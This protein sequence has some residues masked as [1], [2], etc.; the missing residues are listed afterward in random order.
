M[1]ALRVFA[2]LLAGCALGPDYERPATPTAGAYPE[3]GK[4]GDAVRAEWWRS[5]DDP[6]LDAL[7]AKAFAAN[8]DLRV[9]VARIAE[10]GAVLGEVEGAALPQVDA[11]VTSQQI[12][13][14]EGGFNPNLA[15]NGRVRTNHGA[16]I[17]LIPAAPSATQP[18]PLRIAAGTRSD[19]CAAMPHNTTPAARR[20]APAV[21]TAATPKRECSHGNRVSTSAPARKCNVTQAE[22]KPRPHPVRAITACRNTGGP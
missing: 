11:S 20:T 8:T 3:A 14:S 16:I 17:A 10:A 6:E 19:R 13:I 9:A 12:K 4:G 7:V 18:A 5:F 15:L 2:G 1:G 22:T 21:V